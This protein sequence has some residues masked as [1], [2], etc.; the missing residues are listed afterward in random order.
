VFFDERDG[1]IEGRL[2]NP[3]RVALTS[4]SSVRRISSSSARIAS[5]CVSATSTRASV[6]PTRASSRRTRS[7]N[8]SSSEPKLVVRLLANALPQPGGILAGSVVVRRRR[9]HI[10][11]GC[12][13][14]V[15]VSCVVMCAASE[16]GE[17]EI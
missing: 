10:A 7:L 14:L 6:S 12:L 9:G 15:S 5:R 17:S 3:N 16:R 8:A 1:D 13:R 4:F 2:E 11:D